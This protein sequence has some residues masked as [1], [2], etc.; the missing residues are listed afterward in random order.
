[1]T[2]FELWRCY[3]LSI[4]VI[5]WSL[6]QLYTTLTSVILHA[7]KPNPIMFHIYFFWLAGGIGPIFMCHFETVVIHHKQSHDSRLLRLWSSLS[8][9]YYFI[10]KHYILIH[11]PQCNYWILITNLKKNVWNISYVMLL[12]S[13]CIRNDVDQ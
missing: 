3:L 1:M 7:T 8:L 6:F 4:P 12:C 10:L 5:Y 2:F 13:E 11:P 9:V